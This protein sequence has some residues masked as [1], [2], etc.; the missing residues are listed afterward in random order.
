MGD[1]PGQTGAI[2]GAP[3]LD[4]EIGRPQQ[5]IKEREGYTLPSIFN[6]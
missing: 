2:R 5:T 3:P 1:P 4:E 6:I